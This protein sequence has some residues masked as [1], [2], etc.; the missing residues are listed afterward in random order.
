MENVYDIVGHGENGTIEFASG[1]SIR[2][3]RMSASRKSDLGSQFSMGTVGGEFNVAGCTNAI[4]YNSV[5]DLAIV[6]RNGDAASENTPDDDGVMIAGVQ[7][8][9]HS[10]GPQ[11][12]DNVYNSMITF[13]QPG[14][15]N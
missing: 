3:A 1:V 8:I 11:D 12:E 7:C 13:L 2:Y 15:N 5:F 4:L 14:T 10:H 6:L 9:S